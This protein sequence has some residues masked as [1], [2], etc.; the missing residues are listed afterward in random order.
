MTVVSAFAR[1]FTDLSDGLVAVAIAGMAVIVVAQ[2][3]RAPLPVALQRRWE[4]RESSARDRAWAALIA[5]VA[6][7]ELICWAGSPRRDHPT[8]SYFVD[9]VTTHPL[10]RV[11]VFVIWLAIGWLAVT[12]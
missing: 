7:W 8:L 9:L 11:L 10:G 2:Q 5:A 4:D 12:R 1:P 6:A 3:R